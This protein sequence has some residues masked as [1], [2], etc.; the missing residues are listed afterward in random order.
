MKITKSQLKRIVKEELHK[1]KE[2]GLAGHQRKLPRPFPKT[3]KW[4][5]QAFNTV[6]EDEIGFSEPTP[7]QKKAILAG[8][9][10]VMNDMDFWEEELGAPDEEEHAA[11]I[12]SGGGFPL[13][14]PELP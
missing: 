10:S 6:I 4:W 2:G 12:A 11:Y 3:A 9:R 8:L 14:D 7:E 13:T 1:L 5:S